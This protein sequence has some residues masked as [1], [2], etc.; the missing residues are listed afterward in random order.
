MIRE[1]VEKITIERA[2]TCIETYNLKF[3]KNKRS[4]SIYVQCFEPTNLATCF[5]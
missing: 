4:L 1:H 3:A 5:T 2:K